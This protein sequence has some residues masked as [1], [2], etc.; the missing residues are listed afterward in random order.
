[1]HR[2]YKMRTGNTIKKGCLRRQGEGTLKPYGE[3]VEGKVLRPFLRRDL[4]YF[5]VTTAPQFRL[6]R[7]A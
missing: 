5:C 1:M 4:F 3:C 7:L 6:S 2:F